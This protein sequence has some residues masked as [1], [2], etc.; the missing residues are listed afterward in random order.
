[1]QK[2]K[3]EEQQSI[4]N[5]DENSLVAQ[6]DYSKDL[7]LAMKKKTNNVV[8]GLYELQ[9]FDDYNQD[10]Q[11]RGIKS[12]LNDKVNFYS[13]LGLVRELQSDSR[14]RD[15]HIF[16]GGHYGSDKDYFLGAIK[17]TD[18]FECLRV[19]ETNGVNYNKTTEDIIDFLLRWRDEVNFS[20]LD[21]YHDRVV[22]KLEHLNFDLDKFAKESLEFCPDFLSAVENEQE[23]KQYIIDRKDE[24]DFWWD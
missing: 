7:A 18:Q 10:A 15:Y 19:F 2:T 4:L 12:V 20:I 16:S 1:M 11:L 3:L 5:A 23:L 6:L 14:F 13:M 8:E 21:A 9:M 17:T 22:I 24:L